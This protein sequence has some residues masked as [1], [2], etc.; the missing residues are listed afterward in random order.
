MG[1]G[2]LRQRRN[3]LI[4]CILLW[5]ARYAGVTL[6]KANFAGFDVEIKNMDAMFTALW[7]AFAYFL[8]RYYQ[9]FADEGVTN[10]TRTIQKAF[11]EH[12]NP[13]IKELVKETQPESNDGVNY[14]YAVLKHWQWIYQGQCYIKNDKGENVRLD[15]FQLPIQR[16]QLRRE[17]ALALIDAVVRKSAVTDYLLPF[18][19]AAGIIWYCGDAAWKGSFVNLMLE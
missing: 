15:N 10:I 8:Y 16:W 14:S 1:E 4:V 9:Y 12:C 3:L 2:L 17:I 7:I 11:E 6:N 19:I 13:K 18:A 5:F